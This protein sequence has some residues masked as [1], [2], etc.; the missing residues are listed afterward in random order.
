M[1]PK[2]K[3]RCVPSWRGQRS[4]GGRDDAVSPVIGV[5]LMLV[6]TVIIAAVVSGFAGGL[7]GEGS[8]KVPSLSMDVA[9]TNSGGFK[10]SEFSATVLGVS[11]PIPTTDLKI[12][13]SWETTVKTN[14]YVM[15]YPPGEERPGRGCILGLP[16][17]TVYR[18]G[19]EVL[20][21]ITNSYTMKTP[22]SV[23]PYGF[24]PGVNNLTESNIVT[25]PGTSYG[26]IAPI[27]NWQFFTETH[28]GNYSL[29]QGTVMMAE[30]GGRCIYYPAT[31]GVADYD[32]FDMGGYGTRTGDISHTY[33]YKSGNTYRVYE[34]DKIIPT[35]IIADSGQ[36]DGMQAVLGCGWE[37]LRAGDTVNVKVVHIPSGKT[38][39]DK[40]VVVKES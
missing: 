31:G 9:I 26:P 33:Q 24:G 2:G 14:T 20:P 19:A 38:I 27:F 32:F 37:N 4:P 12:V 23:A 29:E 16:L 34:G 36:V 17:G 30:A 6:V 5:M 7:V 35:E 10:G 22:R 28:F 25:M 18:G 40:D 11:E 8:Q 15:E 3:T 1:E 21:G 39:F 13:T